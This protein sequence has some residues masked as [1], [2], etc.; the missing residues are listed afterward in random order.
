[1]TGALAGWKGVRRGWFDLHMHSSASDGRYPP[2]EVLRRAALGGLDVIA[3][4]DHDLAGALSPGE[5]RVEGRDIRVIA[6][7]ELTGRHLGREYHLLVYFPGEPPT[8]FL[9]L[10]RS[11]SQARAERYNAAVSRLDLGL[12][13]ASADAAAGRRALTRHHLGRAL[14]QAGHA[15]SVT[16]GIQRFA[17]REVVPL[18]DLPFVE[19]IRRCRAL[20]GVTSWAH[21]PRQ[22]LL[23]HAQTFARAGLHALEGLRPGMRRQDRT[24]VKRVARRFGL[25]LT[26]GSDWHGWSSGSNLGLFR[27][28]GEDL[29][30]FLDRLSAGCPSVVD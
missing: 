26:G 6:G 10:C 12:E 7:A 23:D 18:I 16:E 15:Q 20:G 21:P 13:P 19:A 1:M 4:T 22:A 14:V 2:A 3:L 11:Q 8:A 25:V 30:P 28:R 5:H 9:D 17:T 24:F 27:I 29:A